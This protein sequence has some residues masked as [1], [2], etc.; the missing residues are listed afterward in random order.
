VQHTSPNQIITNCF[1][2]GN[3]SKVLPQSAVG[4]YLDRIP[5]LKET[6]NKLTTISSHH[7]KWK[8]ESLNLFSECCTVDWLEQRPTVSVF[9]CQN[10][11]SGFSPW[12]SSKGWTWKDKFQLFHNISKQDGS[13][14]QQYLKSINPRW[15]KIR[16]QAVVTTTF[17]L[18]TFFLVFH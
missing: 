10:F 2:V 1:L 11:P 18:A 5:S 7:K 16:T 3:I 17:G 6:K 12:N 8:N 14:N 9:Q 13:D 15:S 4:K